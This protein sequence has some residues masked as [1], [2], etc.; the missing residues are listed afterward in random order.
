MIK[1]ELPLNLEKIEVEK[2][3]YH[4]KQQGLTRSIKTF[5]R[6]LGEHDYCVD[7]A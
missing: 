4:C 2:M 3:G 5:R 6:A 7:S 1:V